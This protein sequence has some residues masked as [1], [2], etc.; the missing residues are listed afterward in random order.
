MHCIILHRESYCAVSILMVRCGDWHCSVTTWNVQCTGSH[1]FI[2]ICDVNENFYETFEYEHHLRK[3]FT[4]AVWVKNST[5]PSSL[6]SD[7]FTSDM[8]T[9]IFSDHVSIYSSIHVVSLSIDSNMEKTVHRA[10]TKPVLT[11][12]ELENREPVLTF[13]TRAVVRTG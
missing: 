4:R 13:T 6:S 12:E 5:I 7:K 9:K 2:F 8:K 11:R 1:I 10:P 3:Q